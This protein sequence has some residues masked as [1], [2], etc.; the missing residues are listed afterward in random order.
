METFKVNDRV[1]RLPFA[2]TVLKEGSDVTASLDEDLE[3]M[4]VTTCGCA[5]VVRAIRSETTNS[6]PENRAKALMVQVLWDNGTLSYH[7]PVALEHVK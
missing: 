4:T 7:G 6:T 1:R 2:V 5:G 3:T